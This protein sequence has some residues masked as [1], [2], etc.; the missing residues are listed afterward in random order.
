MNVNCHVH[1]YLHTKC[2]KLLGGNFSSS[3]GEHTPRAGHCCLATPSCHSLMGLHICRCASSMPY[4]W[5]VHPTCECT[6]KCTPCVSKLQMQSCL[7]SACHAEA[8]MMRYLAPCMSGTL[9]ANAHECAVCV[10]SVPHVWTHLPTADSAPGY[11]MAA[12]WG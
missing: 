6:S 5:A 7:V 9:S 8:C 4:V 2:I 10:S 1:I 11:C 12:M 3:L